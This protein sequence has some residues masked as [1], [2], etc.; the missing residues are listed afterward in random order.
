MLA[1]IKAYILN[2]PLYEN[3]KRK[4]KNDSAPQF[5]ANPTDWY[6]SNWYFLSFLLHLA[7]SWVLSSSS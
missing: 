3:I 1:L 4:F 6:I 5:Q 2:I 7:I